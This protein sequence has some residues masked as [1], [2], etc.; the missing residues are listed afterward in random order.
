MNYIGRSDRAS[1]NALVGTELSPLRARRYDLYQ[2]D[3]FH[4]W[5]GSNSEACLQFILPKKVDCLI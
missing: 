3:D 2:N 4:N 1:N 5:E